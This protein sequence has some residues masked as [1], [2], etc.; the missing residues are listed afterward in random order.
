MLFTLVSFL[1]LATVVSFLCSLWESVLLSITPSYARIKQEEGAV[2]GRHLLT[3]KD[4]IDR[5][6]AAILTLNTI[7]HTVGAIGVGEQAAL[8]WSDTAP[9]VT[10][11]VVPGITTVVILVFSEIIPK[12]LGATHWQRL[13]PFTVL[14][15]KV[16]IWGLWP[17]VWLCQLATRRFKGS[18]EASLFSRSDFLAMTEIGAREGVFEEQHSQM[19]KSLLA[20]DTV[21]VRAIMTPRTVVHRMAEDTSIGEFFQDGRE[22]PFS[23]ILLHRPGDQDDITGYVL[24]ERILAA[25]LDGR[26]DE[27]LRS[28]LREIVVVHPAFPITSLFNRFLETR[29]HIALVVDEFGSMQGIVTLEDVIE[30]MLGTDIVDESDHTTDMQA[31]AR[32]RWLRQARDRGI[33]PSELSGGEGKND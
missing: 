13:A 3:F 9:L 29:E 18:G 32:R 2:I 17:L 31:L 20:Y 19:L 4:N 28:L 11:L 1:L 14:S 23:R 22:V 8:I 25:Q 26:G 27:P 10:G 24:K 21:L 16:I 15:L 12:T 30:T 33:D 5:P 7:A 6:L